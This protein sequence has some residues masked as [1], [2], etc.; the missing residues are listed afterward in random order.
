MILTAHIDVAGTVPIYTINTCRKAAFSGF[1][2]S[3]TP[4]IP[5]FLEFLK[6]PNFIKF[7]KF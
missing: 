7:Q 3:N 6:S 4:E 5:K 2:W 1:P